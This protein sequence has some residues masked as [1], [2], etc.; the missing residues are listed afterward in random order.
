MGRPVTSAKEFVSEMKN[1]HKLGQKDG[2]CLR[3]PLEKQDGA[4]KRTE[5]MSMCG[6]GEDR[7]L[8]VKNS[9]KKTGIYIY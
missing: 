3:N 6:P 1:R 5:M 7:V 4:Q 2:I 8:G 9:S